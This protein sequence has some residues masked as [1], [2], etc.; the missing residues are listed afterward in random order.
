M[1]SQN[2]SNEDRDQR[3]REAGRRRNSTASSTKVDVSRRGIG[4]L[5]AVR[6]VFNLKDIDQSTSNDERI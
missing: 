6:R 3:N 5:D 2:R 1:P 4:F